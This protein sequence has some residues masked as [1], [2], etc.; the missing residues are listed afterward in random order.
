MYTIVYLKNTCILFQEKLFFIISCPDELQKYNA[1]EKAD[2][3]K[4]HGYVYKYTNN[5]TNYI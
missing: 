4:E 3:L 5:A 1:W 2:Y